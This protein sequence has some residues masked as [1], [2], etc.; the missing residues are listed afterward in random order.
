MFSK[1]LRRTHMYLALF[2]T[3]WILVY[4]L[5]TMTM[6]HRQFFTKPG[7]NPIRFERESEQTYTGTFPPQATARQMALQLLKGLNLEGAFSVQ[8]RPEGERI[9]IL[10]QDPISPRRITFVPK[11]GLLL[12]E[13]QVF[14]AHTFLERMHRRRG[15][16]HDRLLEDAWALSVDLVI[17]AMVF[18]VLSGVWMWWEL[19]STRMWGGVCLV[20][21]VGLFGLFLFSI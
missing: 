8:G 17:A 1:F 10:R 20:L 11:S 16:Q 15:Y 2:L 9:T 4:T 12:V 19:R 21:G 18:W 5:S 13:R 7:D 14:S 3:P 6:N